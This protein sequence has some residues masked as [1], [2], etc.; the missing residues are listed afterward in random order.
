LTLPVWTRPPPVKPE[1]VYPGRRARNSSSG[2]RARAS[3]HM[4]AGLRPCA[5]RTRLVR[6]H[7]KLIDLIGGLGDRYPQLKSLTASQA[8]R[9]SHRLPTRCDPMHSTAAAVAGIPSAMFLSVLQQ[10]RVEVMD[11]GTGQRV[12]PKTGRRYGWA[13]TDQLAPN[14]GFLDKLP[15]GQGPEDELKLRKSDAPPIRGMR[16][17]EAQPPRR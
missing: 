15:E 12:D 5:L 13:L 10:F 3:I 6:L 1:S 14:S 7:N 8:R 9:G 11:P 17:R 16:Q 2:A 4:C